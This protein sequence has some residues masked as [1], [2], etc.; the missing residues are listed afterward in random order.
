MEQVVTSKKLS[1][2]RTPKQEKKINI[3]KVNR[4]RDSLSV[5]N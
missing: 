4:K 2:V 3:M 5:S 1:Q